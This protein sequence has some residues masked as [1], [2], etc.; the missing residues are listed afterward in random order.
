MIQLTD[1]SRAARTE[2]VHCS[3]RPIQV[4]A[5][6]VLLAVAGCPQPKDAPVISS[7]DG[8]RSVEARDSADYVCRA[9]DLYPKQLTYSWSQEGGRLGWD[10]GESVR[11]Y[12]PDSSG[13]GLVR[14]TVTDEDG[15]SANDSLV[16][17]VRAETTGILFW[18]GAVKQGQYQAWSDTV[19][20]A[21]K[22]YGYCGADSSNNVLWLMVVDDTNFKE[23]VAGRQSTSL[24]R[25]TIDSRG[26][27]FSVRVDSFDLYHF[28]V[29]NTQ[30]A[31]DRNYWLNILKAGP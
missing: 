28:V 23:W 2:V 9:T 24:L 8:R 20:A 18:D 22:L 4:A 30:G 14:V 16:I 10:W 31:E 5:F 29:D 26:K 25:E 27:A 13:R 12:A 17:T 6:V 1:G 21:Y 3:S 11:W 7:I 15:L 19:R